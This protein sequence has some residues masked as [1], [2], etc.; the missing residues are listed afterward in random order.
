MT[1]VDVYQMMPFS[2][3]I[4][5][6]PDT[7]FMRAKRTYELMRQLVERADFACRWGSP[8]QHS[9]AHADWMKVFHESRANIESANRLIA[10][11]NHWVYREDDPGF[12][13][14]S[15]S[16]PRL[17]DGEPALPPNDNAVFFRTER[18]STAAILIPTHWTWEQCETFA[19]TRG[20][21]VEQIEYPWHYPYKT[22]AV[23][24]TRSS[25]R[26]RPL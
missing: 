12:S 17:P 18:S 19:R 24:Y 3:P 5:G 16:N 13:F 15:L 2:P 14:D 6:L 25:R 26:K 10:L 9:A 21:Y 11:I 8:A 7:P 20:L 22:V 4:T 23:L 1:N